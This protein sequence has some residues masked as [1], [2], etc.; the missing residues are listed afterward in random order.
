[1]P[2]AVPYPSTDGACSSDMAG[3]L[4]GF[5]A[6]HFLMLLHGGTPFGGHTIKTKKDHIISMWVHAL[7]S[8]AFSMQFAGDCSI[9]LSQKI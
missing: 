8:K 6:V 5:M 7:M 2:Q 9:E 4:K 3:C 1:M